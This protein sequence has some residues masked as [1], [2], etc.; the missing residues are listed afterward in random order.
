MLDEWQTFNATA[1][2]IEYFDWIGDRKY[3]SKNLPVV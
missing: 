3:L 1:V 2:K